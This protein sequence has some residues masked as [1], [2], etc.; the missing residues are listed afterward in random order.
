VGGR[1]SQEI[2]LS[3]AF[4]PLTVSQTFSCRKT[5][6]KS[7][8]F[9]VEQW[10]NSYPVH[11]KPA[12]AFSGILYPLPHRLALRFAF[13]KGGQRAYHVPRKYQLSDLGSILT[14]VGLHLRQRKA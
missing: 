8:R 4:P 11:Y 14:P 6:R 10:L 2:L 5:C 13:P 1:T 7:A 12:F 9:R 3:S